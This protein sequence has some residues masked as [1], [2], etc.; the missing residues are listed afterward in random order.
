MA[1]RYDAWYDSPKG[2]RLFTVEIACIRLA[3]GQPPPHP[4]LEVGVG[5]GR[6]AAALAVDE[7]TDTAAAP[8]ALA[9]Q[10]GVCVRQAPA[11]R[12]PLG[13][14]GRGGARLCRP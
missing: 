2:A 8:L 5:T 12:L 13:G 4:W 14:A 6:F 7:G 10:R 11:E 3:L 9:A 1:E